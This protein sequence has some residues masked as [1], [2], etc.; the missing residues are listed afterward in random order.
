MND[1]KYIVRFKP[2]ETST[3]TVVAATAEVEDNYLVL[4]MAD[5][6]LAALFAMDVVE[7]WGEV[8]N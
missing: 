2:P 7:N 5:G 3:Q 6:E 1:R 8:S 4:L